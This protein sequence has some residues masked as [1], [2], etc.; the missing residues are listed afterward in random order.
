MR[1][2]LATAPCASPR[3]RPLGG[4]GPSPLRALQHVSSRPRILHR[5]RTRATARQSVPPTRVLGPS[6]PRDPMVPIDPCATRLWSSQHHA[7]PPPFFS[8]SSLAPPL[9]RRDRR[10][11]T[12]GALLQGRVCSAIFMT[13]SP[14]ETPC[15]TPRLSTLCATRQAILRA[16]APR[17][18][19]RP[20]ACAP[21]CSNAH[22]NGQPP[23]TRSCTPPRTP[24]CTPSCT[25]CCPMQQQCCSYISTSVYIYT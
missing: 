6:A 18:H 5:S 22:P 25:P 4:R 7:R 12:D 16:L 21:A 17:P 9:L 13:P 14:A 15:P 3:L 24:L 1:K 8:P 20:P 23:S 10:A 11:W 19:E 2:E